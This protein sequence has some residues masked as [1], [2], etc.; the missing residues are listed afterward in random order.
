MSDTNLRVISFESKFLFLE[1]NDFLLVSLPLNSIWISL[2]D[3]DFIN[4]WSPVDDQETLSIF[5]YLEMTVKR[6]MILYFL[7]ETVIV[8]DTVNPLRS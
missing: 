7:I 6:L 5:R 2:Q 1:L 3:E 4:N 8:F